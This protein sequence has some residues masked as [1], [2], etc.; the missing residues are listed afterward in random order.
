MTPSIVAVVTA[1]EP[2]ASLVG[3]CA[4]ALP[5]VD[6]VI[7]VDDGSSSDV[8]EVLQQC[9]E[10]GCTVIRTGENRGIAHALNSGVTRALADGAD[11]VLTLDQDTTL[12]DDYAARCTGHL[13]LARSLGLEDLML[14]T[15]TLNGLVAPFW[16]AHEGLTLAFEPIQSGMVITRSLFERIGLFEEGLF[17][18]CVETEFYLR[19]RAHGAH[20]LIVPG[21]AMEHAMGKP[22]VWAPRWPMTLLLRKT[23]GRFEFRGDAA[24]RHYYIM[25]N[26]WVVYRR[27]ARREPLWCLVS[28]LKDSLARGGLFVM[29]D[30]RLARMY[31]TWAGL[32]AGMRGETGKIPDRILRRA[33]LAR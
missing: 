26:R 13:V 23:G 30:H 25:R 5:Q 31:L 14:S 24:F 2:G 3:T 18:D 27:Y 7:V 29:G 21:A 16:F 9:R 22:L 12:A 28:V 8:T 15:A 17:I 10:M 4:A 20:A 11:A 6:G 33:G 19:A 32:R 1:F